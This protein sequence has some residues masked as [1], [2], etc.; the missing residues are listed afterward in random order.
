MVNTHKVK[1]VY[2]KGF[3]QTKQQLNEPRLKKILEIVQNQ[4][5]KHVDNLLDIGCG[6]GFFTQ[7]LSKILKPKEVYGID[8]SKEAVQNLNSKKIKGFCIDVDESDLPFPSNFFD[9]VYCGNLIELVADADHLFK[10]IYRTLKKEG[11]A[12]ITFPNMASWL[13]RI[14]LLFG[15]LP[16]YSRV[17]TQYDFGKMFLKTKKGQSTGFIRLFT[18]SSFQK[19]TEL[20]N[21]KIKKVY[22]TQENTLPKPVKFIDNIMSVSP[23]FAFQIICVLTKT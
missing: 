18:L 17:S 13:S 8:I 21:L 19:F 20:Y 11:T 10:E 9:F 23:S 7:E 1:L 16:Y 2:Q 12:I 5:S 22:G 3:A 6:D 14:A 4:F 15:Y